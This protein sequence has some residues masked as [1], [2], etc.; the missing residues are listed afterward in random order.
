LF[1]GSLMLS[2]G[3]VGCAV[4]PSES[5]S[6]SEAIGA[7]GQAIAGGMLDTVDTAV[8]GIV[9]VGQGFSSCSGTLIAPN[10]VLTAHH[11]VAQ[12]NGGQGVNCATSSF[13]AV[14]PAER[15]YVTTK[16]SLTAKPSDYHAVKQI[17]VPPG[18]GFCGND[19]AIMVLS[20]P[21]DANEAKPRVARVDTSVAYKE[22][23]YAVGYGQTGE[24]GKSGTR[25]RRDGLFA[26]CVGK[27]CVTSQIAA[28]EWLGDTGVCQ[29]DSGGPA[30]DL[31][32]RVIGVASRGA[33][34]CAYPT[35]AHV[36]GV[37][38]WLKETVVKATKDGGVDT[39]TWA[40]GFPTD[41]KFNF[42]VGGACTQP[43]DCPSNACLDGYC[44][45]LCTELATC[46]TGYTCSEAGYCEKPAAAEPEPAAE[47][48]AGSKSY[49]VS[50]CAAGGGEDP[51]KPI[52]WIVSAALAVAC[53]LRRRR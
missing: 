33:A 8:V 52:P 13:G 17:V 7:I 9:S 32:D 46:P 19:V 16:T 29:G 44:T 38:D 30:F 12:T 4:A 35:Y 53:S 48:N 43:S 28:S 45:R 1:A 50:S 22:Q 20:Q 14:R 49:Q 37:A 26:R 6:L 36:H 40:E 10:V 3:F 27:G 11:C 31:Q 21:I 47:A 51:T 41:P 34:G 18:S 24:N 15:M 25:Y 23:Y 39:P 5:D 2:I 42:D